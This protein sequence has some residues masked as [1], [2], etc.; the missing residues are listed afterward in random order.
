VRKNVDKA[1]STRFPASDRLLGL[2]ERAQDPPLYR[3]QRYGKQE[4]P[5]Y[6]KIYP[7][8]SH[9][10]PNHVIRRTYVLDTICRSQ[11]K[12]NRHI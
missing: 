10:Y 2:G 11:T 9:R 7:N 8:I 3:G 6:P 12:I 5:F 1:W 4:T